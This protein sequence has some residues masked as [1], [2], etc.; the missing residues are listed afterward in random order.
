MLHDLPS[1]MAGLVALHTVS[2]CFMYLPSTRHAYEWSDSF[3]SN[4]MVGFPWWGASAA[5]D[6]V[7]RMRLFFSLS[8][9][10]WNPGTGKSRIERLGNL[11]GMHTKRRGAF[12]GKGATR[13]F[14]HPG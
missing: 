13:C 2:L 1:A 4:P 7:T 14:Q 11:D 6:A 12:I 10:L 9:N 8:I 3:L 5:R